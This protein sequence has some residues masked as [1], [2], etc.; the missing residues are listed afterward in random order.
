[1][2]VTDQDSQLK[3]REAFP[4]EDLETPLREFDAVQ[5]DAVGRS[6]SRRTAAGE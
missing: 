4:Y 2:R 5:G 3:L 6:P 1:L